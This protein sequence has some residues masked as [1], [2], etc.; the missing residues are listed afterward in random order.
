MPFKDGP[1]LFI[2]NFGESKDLIMLFKDYLEN[3]EYKKVWF[4]YGFDRHIFY[5][6]GI[7]C[8]GFHGDS[9]QMAR[10]LDSSKEPNQYSLSKLSNIYQKQIMQA[11][12]NMLDYLC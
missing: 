12:H 10:L 6:H 9:M 8:Q 7:D 3:P 2:D 1:R 5:N 11:K 4:N